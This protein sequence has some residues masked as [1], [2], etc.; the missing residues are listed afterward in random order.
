MG[1]LLTLPGSGGRELE[2][3]YGLYEALAQFEA[4]V[5]YGRVADS[6]STAIS[7]LYAVSLSR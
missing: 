1:R 6:R 7:T 2:G 5:V 4:P 3:F